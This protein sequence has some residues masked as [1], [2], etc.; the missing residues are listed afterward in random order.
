[1]AKFIVRGALLVASLGGSTPPQASLS[2]AWHTVEARDA[3]GRD[4]TDRNER[5]ILMFTRDHFTIVWSELDRP[6]FTGPLSNS[7]KAALW[8]GFRAQAGPYAVAPH[9]L[10]L[11]SQ[12]ANNP[13]AT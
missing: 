11:Y 6:R 10:T 1:M 9:T 8:Q 13:N 3:R 2:G 4:I 12:L 7:Q 5:N